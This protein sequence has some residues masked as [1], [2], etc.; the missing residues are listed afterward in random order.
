MALQRVGQRLRGERAGGEDGEVG[1]V[2]GRESRTSSRMDGDVG[3]G[4]EALGDAARR[5]RRGRRRGRGRRGRRWRRRR[6]AGSEPA[7]R[8]S[9]LSS[10]GA[11]FSDSRFER[12]GADEFGEVGGLVGLG[13]AMRAHLVELDLLAAG[14]GL[15]RGFRAGEASADHANLLQTIDDGTLR[16]RACPRRL[17]RLLHPERMPLRRTPL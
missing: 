5:R 16:T 14:G 10:Q 2:S 8:I 9:C 11:V 12:V 6:R 13:G 3:L 15:Q 4:G 17:H 7:R 1:V